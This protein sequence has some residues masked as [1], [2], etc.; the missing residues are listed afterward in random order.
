M[1]LKLFANLGNLV[2]SISDALDL[3]YPSLAMHQQRVAFIAWEL[4]KKA[5]LDEKRIERIFLA[6]LLHDIGALSSEEKRTLHANETTRVDDHCIRGSN[7]F[8]SN[9]WLSDGADLIKYHHRGWDDWQTPR[10]T[11]LVFDSQLLYLADHLE[12]HVNRKKYILQQKRGP[13]YRH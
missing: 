9:P 3:A 5:R 11:P 12:R 1:Q 10:D 2:L 13:L 6:G 8:K 4:A 7:L